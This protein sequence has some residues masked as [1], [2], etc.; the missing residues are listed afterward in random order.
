MNVIIDG[1]VAFM[2]NLIPVCTFIIASVGLGL[3][4]LSFFPVLRGLARGQKIILA[5]VVGL[6]LLSIF[7]YGF[8]QLARVWS[9]AFTIGSRLIFVTSLVFV[10][11]FLR[12][13][14]KKRQTLKEW[15]IAG[16]GLL[17]FILFLSL[18]LVYLKGL[19]LPPY[20]DSV[21]HY[22]ILVNFLNPA[23]TPGLFSEG[24]YHFGF[25]SIAAWLVEL[26]GAAPETALVLL[27]QFFLSIVPLSL[28]SFIHALTHNWK[29]SLITALIGAFTWSMPAH[30]ANWGKYPAMAAVIILP[31]LLAL[32][33]L[34]LDRKSVV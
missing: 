20:H 4:W 32:L 13:T 16:I 5:P 27:G 10:I 33:I 31:A 25:H 7:S 12:D 28:Y 19:V 34:L 8:I 29:P 1:L 23:T 18:R 2:R 22:R 6:L 15:G 17:C 21:E 14:W 26:A 30:A 9:P 3:A 11:L 24:Y